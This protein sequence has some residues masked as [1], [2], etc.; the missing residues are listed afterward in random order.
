M[1]REV[2]VLLTGVGKRYDIVSAFAR[3]AT[4]VAADP[5]PLA[6]A[7]YAAHHHCAVPRIDDPEYVPALRELCERHRVGAVV[8]LTDLDIEVLAH[9]RAAG[10]LPAFVPDPEIARAT[11]DK[12]EAHLLLQRLGLPSP[13][14]M[15]PGEPIPYFPAMVK[16]RR[17][18][19]ARSIHRV[20]DAEAAAF[21][22]RYIAE[23]AMVQKLMDGPEFSIDTL[24]DLQGRC[25]N[26]IPRTMIESRGGESIKGT[27][28]ADPELIALG[29]RVVEALAV[30][31]PCTVQVFRDSE[32]GL[33]IT[34]VNTRFGGAFPAP[35][36]A[37]LP[38]R[39]YPHLIVRIARGEEVAPH[40]GEFKAGVT[41]TR[42]FWQL[43]LDEQLRPTGRDIVAPPGP[44]RPRSAE[45]FGP[46][47]LG[48]RARLSERVRLRPVEVWDAEEVYELVAADRE[49]LAR[50]MPWAVA[51]TLDAIRA[52][53]ESTRVRLLTDNGFECAIVRDDR[54]VGTV[55]YHGVNWHHRS[56]SLGYWL[57]AAEQGQGTMMA[58]VRA[59]VG[60][61][62]GVWNLNRVVIEAAVENT[63][64][65]VLARRLGFRE[66]GVR[67]QA[68]RI[69]DRYL[70][71]VVHA[72]LASEWE[73]G[74]AAR[75]RRPTPGGRS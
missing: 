49:H 39:T 27:V 70:D 52:F 24:S 30:R 21:M 32:I 61:A 56:T 28:I 44:P 37:A 19:G 20:D 23:P 63:R 40:V 35:M 57:I 6:P 74:E 73:A 36:Y 45:L 14:T 10:E 67:R 53:I 16:P 65:R 3:H 43:E 13:P 31:G 2:G 22:V 50:F 38:D 51:P 25:L 69:G 60:H 12:Y 17:G 46:N 11:F 64:S 5:N 66:E 55:G 75:R 42:Y 34:D 58:A 41:F 8:P 68:E 54:I 15:L 71:N 18:S 59:L 48:A 4:V 62:F 72:M 26:A 1:A 47:P 7:Q 9:A 33:G 29:K